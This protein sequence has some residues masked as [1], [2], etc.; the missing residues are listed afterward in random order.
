MQ[1]HDDF[2]KKS[3][4]AQRIGTEISE[5]LLT[6]PEAEREKTLRK[7]AAQT[8][9]ELR[10]HRT[11]N[12][13]HNALA[14]MI[15]WHDDH[16]VG[17]PIEFKDI[18]QSALHQLEESPIA[19]SLPSPVS[20]GVSEIISRLKTAQVFLLRHNWGAAFTGAENFDGEVRPP[21][22]TCAFEFSANGRR[23]IA[24]VFD[25]HMEPHIF[26]RCTEAWVHINNDVTWST[27]WDLVRAACIALEAEVAVTDV[28][29]APAALNK[30]RAKRNRPPLHDF[31]IVRLSDRHRVDPV[32]A[33]T[34]D[35]HRPRLHFRRGHWRHFEAHKTWIKWQLVG[36]PDLGFVDKEYRL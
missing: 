23:C 25:G 11:L 7:L 18:D 5:I 28:I 22:D 17:T 13:E 9:I 24:A 16:P 6:L 31:H 33:H 32:A 19:S 8:G 14:E 26:V 29:R 27:M 21:Y 4:D 20:N 1:T 10:N 36:S 30:S 34:S 2:M 3:R 15:K 12:A 35:R